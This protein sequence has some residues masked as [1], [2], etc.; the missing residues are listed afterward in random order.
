M[1]ITNLV[2]DPVALTLTITAEFPVPVR[3]VWD[4]YADPRLLERFW[5]PP[6]WPATFTRHDMAIGGRSEYTMRGPDGGT[7][8]GYWEFIDVQA[9][10][11]FEVRDGFL[12]PDGKPNNDLPSM[13]MVFH[14]EETSGGSR[15]VTTTHFPSAEALE[16]LLSMGMEEGA[17][18]ATGQMDAVLAD[19]ASFAANRGTEVQ[20][21]PGTQVR[22]SRVIRGNIQQVWR[23][24]Q[25]PEWIQRWMLGPEG[26]EMPVC[27]V[28]GRVGESYR[29]EWT[30]AAG[31][32][33]VGQPGFAFEGEL[34]SSLPPYRAVSTERMVG[35]PGPGTTNELTLTELQHGTLMSLLITY[36]NA[37]LRDLVLGTGMA[38][39]MEASYARLEAQ[40]GIRSPRDAQTQ[41]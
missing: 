7:S 30:P 5:G 18:Q 31:G 15:V 40:V 21:L 37:E 28:A 6:T 29:Y 9:P 23:A 25:E 34:L 35:V 36:P 11:R 32:P 3:R 20:V 41:P 14:F 10:H 12:G 17:R 26:W 19:L 22:I 4:A 24:H 2:K 13:R 27:K 16:Q 1:P 33:A 38:Q 39:G 8:S